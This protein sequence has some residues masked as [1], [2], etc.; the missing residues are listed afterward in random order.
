MEIM[1]YVIYIEIIAVAWYNLLKRSDSITKVI[2]IPL[3][4][5]LFV[6][7]FFEG[8]GFFINLSGSFFTF[9]LLY[10]ASAVSDWITRKRH[11]RGTKEQVWKWKMNNWMGYTDD[12]H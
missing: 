4:V 6:I 10:K 12:F 3:A 9:W 7:G 11:F 5:L 8:Y 2:G 1:L